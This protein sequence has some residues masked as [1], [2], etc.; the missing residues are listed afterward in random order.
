MRSLLLAAVGF[1]ALA[2]GPGVA[3]DTLPTP[4]TTDAAAKM[5]AAIRSKVESLSPEEQQ[6]TVRIL[7]NRIDELGQQAKELQDKL[8]TARSAEARN[9]SMRGR[10]SA[11][12]IEKRYEAVQSTLV[13]YSTAREVTTK[14]DSDIPFDL[15][16]PVNE[17]FAQFFGPLFIVC[18][19]AIWAPADPKDY[20]GALA[21]NLLKLLQMGRSV[22]RIE[23]SQNGTPAVGTGFLVGP[24]HVLTNRHVITDFNLAARDP[25]TKEW[26]LRETPATVIRFHHEFDLQ[27]GN[28]CPQRP[29]THLVRVV[30]ILT[31]DDNVDL[32][33]LILLPSAQDEARLPPVLPLQDR[34]T[35]EYKYATRIAVIG[36]P[37][38][39]SDM[40]VRQFDEYFRTPFR[41]VGETGIKRLSPGETGYDEYDQSVK[42]NEFRHNANTAGGNSGGP[43]IDVE[44]QAVIGVHTRALARQGNPESINY[45]IMS[46]AA[47]GIVDAALK[48]TQGQ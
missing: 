21:Q 18:D 6:K 36:Y 27:A 8:G 26:K 42:A 35:D 16:Q 47:K 13:A 46:A 20:R 28:G 43:V 19:S 4:I 44:L 10:E 15:I 31:P 29:A 32:A 7:D 23:L 40:T 30:G 48:A 38:R 9:V 34:A 1:L 12:N 45:G 2:S 11:E 24:R 39:P 37:G 14:P 33:V 41:T 5:T 22:G 17:A 3:Q 25:N